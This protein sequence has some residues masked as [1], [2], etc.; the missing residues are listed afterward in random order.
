MTPKMNDEQA[1]IV[2]LQAL[3]YLVGDERVLLRF[4][5]FSGVDLSDLRARAD[6]PSFLAGVLEFFLGFEP[7]LLEMCKATG[8]PAEAPAQARWC[9]LG[10]QIEEWS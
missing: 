7:Q 5:D 10:V 4:I 3:T 2:A 1:K 9:L 6:D 8:L